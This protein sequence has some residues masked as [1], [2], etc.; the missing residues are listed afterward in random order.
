MP[1][2]IYHVL[3]G[4]EPVQA[5]FAKQIQVGQAEQHEEISRNISWKPNKSSPSCGPCSGGELRFYRDEA[6]ESR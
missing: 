1:L 6:D 2:P 3:P 5:N 4:F